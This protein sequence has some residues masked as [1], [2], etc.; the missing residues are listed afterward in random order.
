MPVIKLI[1]VG[2][3][4]ALGVVMIGHGGVTFAGPP[5]VREN[6]ARW[7]YP[8]GFHLVQGVLEVVVGLL[9]LIPVTSQVGAIASAMIVLAAVVIQI[10]SGDWGN[11][12]FAAVL[13]A[14]SVAAIAI[15]R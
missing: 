10:R 8:A 3:P 1:S 12:P 11:L 2:L 13:M 6:F 4:I 7:G 5:L 14:A 15:H 9:L